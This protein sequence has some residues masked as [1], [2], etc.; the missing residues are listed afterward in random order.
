MSDKLIMM[1]CVIMFHWD[2]L[3]HLFINME[4]NVSKLDCNYFLFSIVEIDERFVGD[5]CIGL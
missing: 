2:K 3:C 1:F 4:C 5:F